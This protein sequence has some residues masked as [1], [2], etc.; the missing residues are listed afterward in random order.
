[1]LEYCFNARSQNLLNVP[2]F[3]TRQFFSVVF[4]L[5]LS[6]EGR[7]GK[8]AFEHWFQNWNF[9]AKWKRWFNAWWLQLCWLVYMRLIGLKLCF[10]CKT[11]C[12]TTSNNNDK[13]PIINSD[14]FFRAK[15]FE[16]LHGGSKNTELS[17]PR[18]FLT[19]TACVKEISEFRNSTKT[20]FSVFV[21]LFWI[22]IW[23]C[24][25]CWTDERDLKRFHSLKQTP[26][27]KFMI[28]WAHCARR[29][30]TTMGNSSWW[31]D[32]SEPIKPDQDSGKWWLIVA[33]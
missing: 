30:L 12:V 3:L 28:V 18:N 25:F 19:K 6:C 13:I 14:F 23:S 21:Y 4:P 8:P 27:R 17:F 22:E 29:S 1:M 16:F 10:V 33:H 2:L 9:F 20:V 24:F 26:Q 32:S 5:W 11:S 7:R 15:M 31:A